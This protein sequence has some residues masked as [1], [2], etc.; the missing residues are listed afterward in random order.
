MASTSATP[1]TFNGGKMTHLFA[2]DPTS[3]GKYNMTDPQFTCPEAERALA[4][5]KAWIKVHGENA[6]L[7]RDFIPGTDGNDGHWKWVPHK[8]YDIR[9]VDNLDAVITKG[10]KSGKLIRQLVKGQPREYTSPGKNGKSG[11]GHFY[12]YERIDPNQVTKKGDRV[13][14][15]TYAAIATGVAD[16]RLPDPSKADCPNH[17]TF[18]WVGVKHQGN[19]DDWPCNHGLV[20]HN[21]AV[22]ENPPRSFEELWS[23]SKTEMMEGI[24]YQDPVSAT[25][26]KFRFNM[27]PGAAYQRVESKECKTH[28][29]QRPDVIYAK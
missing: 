14:P 21:D 18:E 17:L 7:F 25:F 10:A 3:Y 22:L 26:F 16:G 27:C 28:E 8:R 15:E 29:H 24:I 4:A 11:K 5:G 20:I 19:T 23:M 6:C 9:S 1:T 13:G 2:T 12:V